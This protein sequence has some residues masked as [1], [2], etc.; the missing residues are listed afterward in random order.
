MT[1]VVM[2]GAILWGVLA[3]TVPAQAKSPETP[4]LS[5]SAPCSAPSDLAWDGRDLWVATV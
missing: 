2:I 5:L 3:G 4:V 1:R